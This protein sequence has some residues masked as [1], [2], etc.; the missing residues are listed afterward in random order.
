VD[1]FAPDAVILDV[2]LPDM[3]GFEVLRQVRQRSSVPIIMLTSR[4]EERNKV[5]GLMGGADDYVTKPFSVPELMAR[6]TT[7]LRRARRREEASAP[8]PIT[9]GDVVIDIA[10]GRVYRAGEPLAITATE[11][12]LLKA[13]AENAGRVMV[14]DD[15][16]RRVWGPGYEGDSSLLRTTVG[17]LRQK[18]GDGAGDVIQNVRGIGYMFEAPTG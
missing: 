18:L 4:T 10:A 7:I 12:K 6:L 9:A 17:R 13:L 8:A 16:L 11:F 5:Q 1:E 3:D 14:T 15:L 2:V